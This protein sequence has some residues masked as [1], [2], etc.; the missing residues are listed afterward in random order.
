MAETWDY[1]IVTASNDLQAAAYESQ[2]SLRRR[3]GLLDDVRHVLIVSDPQGKRIGSGGSTIYCLMRVLSR[4]LAQQGADGRDQEVWEE[5]L[6]HLRILI[7]HAGGDSKRLPA[8]GPCGKIFVPIP[9]PGP[10]DAAVPPALF[11]RLV[12]TFM[13]LPPMPDGGGQVVVT[14]GDAL[15]DFDPSQVRFDAKGMTALGCHATPEHA[16]RHGVFCEGEDRQVRL[17]LQKPSVEVQRDMGAVD[18]DGQSILDVAVMGFDVATSMALLR[19]FDATVS[20][21]GQLVWPVVQFQAI[22]ANGVDM[23]REICCAMGSEA[24]VEHHVTA[25]RASGSTWD[26]VSLA[27]MCEA[28]SSVPFSIQVLDRCDFLHFGTTRQLITSGHKLMELDGGVST[29]GGNL[30]VNNDIAE[31]ALVSGVDSWV[32]GSRIGA[33][34]ELGGE[35]VVVGVDCDRPLALPPKACLDVLQGKTRDGARAWFVRCY[36]VTDQIKDKAS[37]GA[38]FCNVPVLQWLEMVGATPADAW[39]S[40]EDEASLTVW[41][42]NLF[43]AVS[44]PDGFRDWLWMFEPAAATGDQKR[45]WREAPRYNLAEMAVLTDQDAFHDRRAELWNACSR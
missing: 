17:F 24:T 19:M 44:E 3:L 2:L 33:T 39:E 22:L 29:A 35:N 25:S 27:G 41:D 20:E 32:E 10:T 42:A 9:V 31:P 26:D 18:P 43:P 14:S 5:I 45:A 38:T 34:L 16:S 7:V 4:E 37:A 11:D 13:A 6:S 1:L 36:G 40:P 21:A 15:I 12:P 8:Y 28:L 30:L 23:Y